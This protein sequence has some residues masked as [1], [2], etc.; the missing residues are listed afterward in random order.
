TR[1]RRVLAAIDHRQPD[2]VPIDLGGTPSSGISAVAYNRLIDHLGLNVGPAKVYDVVQQLAQPDKKLLDYLGVDVIDVGQAFN[3]T[4][5]SWRAATLPS[6]EEVFLPAWFRPTVGA[7]GGWEVFASDGTRIAAMPAKG[8]FFDQTCFPYVDGYPADFRDLDRAMGKVLWAALVHSPWDH[9]GEDAFWDVLRARAIELR[10]S[11]DRAIII[12]GGCNLFEW[13]SFL[14][15][16]DRFLMDLASAPRDVERLLD[17]LMERYLAFLEKLCRAVGD[18]V[19]VVRLGDDLGMDQG[20]FMSPAMYRRLFKPRHKTLC[21]YIHAHSAMRIFLHSCGGISPLIPDLIE[22][23]FEILNPVQTN[24]R[25]MD[26]EFLKQEFGRDVT[27]WGGGCDTRHVLNR[28]SPSEV[29][30]HVRE[31]LDAFARDGGFV[32]N[33]VHNILPEVPPENIV[34]M[35]EALAEYNE[36]A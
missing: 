31:R 3:R 36:H 7:D 20:P 18:V 35:F 12:A 29:K 6:K 9:A 8:H 33:T 17:A 1:R 23:G 24:C 19:D 15:R 13:G 30:R 26:P 2:R 28:G 22:A 11:T 14:R 10:A 21:D 5:E 4:P 16:L 27:F 25:G 34:A 32:F